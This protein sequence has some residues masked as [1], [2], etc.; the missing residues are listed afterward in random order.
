MHSSISSFDFSPLLK[1]GG[2][3][4]A[5]ILLAWIIVPHRAP[6][7]ERA[8]FGPQTMNELTIEQYLFEYPRKPIVVAGSSVVTLTP[9]AHCRPPNVATL[10]LQ[11]R[12]AITGLEAIRRSGSRPQ[13]VFI[14]VP[15][16]FHILDLPLL[17]AVFRPY[18]WRFRTLIPPLRL[19]RNWLVMFYHKI[20]YESAGDIYAYPVP[21]EPVDAWNEA[22]A[23]NFA[24]YLREAVQDE[25]VRLATAA[26]VPR[27][28]ELQQ[29]GTRVI[30][31]DSAD[32]RIRARSP[33]KEL[34]ASLRAALPD[35]EYIDA[36]DP[37][38]PIYRYD[39]RH[40][41]E[42]S[43]VQFFEFLMNYAGLPF[44]PKCGVLP[45]RPV[46]Q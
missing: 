39:G 19:N 46:A 9:P 42:S 2:T 23:V 24:G 40:F 34:R 27:V 22:H 36:P 15:S 13:V 29:Q 41:T 30:L 31:F 8:A 10:Y 6:S 33:E 1:A 7:D 25:D 35:V 32:W 4:L 28:R 5:T 3:A 16:L 26:L 11:G 18:Y 38:V 37:E 45:S 43:G 21:A 44:T 12:G 17:D 20:L 14:E